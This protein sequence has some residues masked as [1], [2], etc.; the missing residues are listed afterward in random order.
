MVN[1]RLLA[2]GRALVPAY[3]SSV[4]RFDQDLAIPIPPVPSLE[5]IRRL[6]AMDPGSD[7]YRF[8]LTA[9]VRGRNRTAFYLRQALEEARAGCAE[10]EAVLSA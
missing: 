7:E 6:V 10:L 2:V 8:L 5:G 9:L 3:F 4:E 1:R